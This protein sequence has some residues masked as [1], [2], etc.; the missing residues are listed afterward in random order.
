MSEVTI[1]FLGAT[2]TVTGSRFLVSSAQ[3]KVLV[4]CGLFQG[5][6]SIRKKNWDAFP[7][8]VKTI[9]SVVLTHAHLDHC[10]Y[11]PLLARQGY[12]NPIFATHY[13]AELASVILHDSA[14]LQMEDA[15]YALKKGYSKHEV[16]LPLYNVD[17]TE[18]ALKLFKRVPFHARMQVA[19]D[20]WATWYPSGH[21]LGAG[22]L[23]LEIGGK[24][25]LF[26]GDMGR[27]NHP[28]L[29]NPDNPPSL[30]LDAVITEST[31]GDRKHDAKPEDFARELNAAI[32]RGGSILIPAFAVDRTEVILMALR[33]LM[34]QGLVPVVPVYVDSPMALTALNFYR[35]AI[36]QD[37]PEIRDGVSDK[38]TNQDPFDSG[39]LM[40]ALT[41]EESKEIN[42]ITETSII[43]S[44]SGMA[45]GGRVVHHLEHML[46]EP[47]N[48]VILV[49]Y[50]AV[51]SRGRLL[52]E[53]SAEI[54]MH[55]KMVPVRAHISKVESFSVHADADEL[56]AWLGKAQK[57][58]KIFVIH[59]EQ[60]AQE[61]MANRISDQLNWNAIV[62]K[63]SQVISI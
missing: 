33:E 31:Y 19:P 57:P 14:H 58:G 11:L 43:I 24:N 6:K 9:D 38:W 34:E 17:D 60:G 50:Q 15:K 37:T 21:I 46:P 5:V 13:T 40:Q 44:A 45:T 55:G 29:S 41:T 16:P 59:G 35:E 51:G 1:A 56:I 39:K 18:A 8:D 53:G 22:F 61:A 49:G 63:P 3:S 7:V 12:E 47:K 25:L 26:T 62:P 2:D 10:G 48:T 20:A 4:D 52:E 30:K 32:K 54:K 36:T 27:N 23:L 42:D 28:L